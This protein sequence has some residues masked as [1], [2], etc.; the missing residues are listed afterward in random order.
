MSTR[1]REKTEKRRANKDNRPFAKAK[2]I[3]MSSS[4]VR[5]VLDLIRGK[6]AEEAVAILENSTQSAAEVSV[7]VLK[8]AIANAENNKGLKRADLYVAE[9]YACPGPTLKRLNIRA[10]G[11]A[12]RMLKRT[13]HITI[14]LDSKE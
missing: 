4:K 6:K 10:R 3:R 5:I 11:R 2:Y 1:L 9:A 8:S 13:S 12:D 14:V 7:K